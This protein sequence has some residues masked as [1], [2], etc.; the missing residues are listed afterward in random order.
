MAAHENYTH[1]WYLCN[2]A[3]NIIEWSVARILVKK[4]K[5]AESVFASPCK[6]LSAGL[7][8]LLRGSNLHGRCLLLRGVSLYEQ[9][10]KSPW[11]LSLALFSGKMVVASWA[12]SQLNTLCLL[13]WI[14]IEY[15]R[16]L[17]SHLIII[18]P[19]VC[20]RNIP[21]FWYRRLTL[22]ENRQSEPPPLPQPQHTFAHSGKALI[23]SY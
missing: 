14:C 7:S 3:H 11:V 12:G 8:N 9:V 21:S 5:G 1:I 6:P 2:A 18:V 13:Q 19:I 4:E 16:C 22:Y 23:A 15:L 20:N 17:L 10:K